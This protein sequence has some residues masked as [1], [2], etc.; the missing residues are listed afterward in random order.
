MLDECDG[1]NFQK[2]PNMATSWRVTMKIS[3]ACGFI[4]QCKSAKL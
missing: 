2:F 3:S 1:E 4:F